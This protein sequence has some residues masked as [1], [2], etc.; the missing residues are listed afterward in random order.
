MDD[1]QHAAQVHMLVNTVVVLAIYVTYRLIKSVVKKIISL[2][3]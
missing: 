1:I 2:F 3:R